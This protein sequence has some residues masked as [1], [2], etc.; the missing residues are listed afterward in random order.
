MTQL[1][2]WLAQHAGHRR[3][4]VPDFTSVRWVSSRL[5]QQGV[6]TL[7]LRVE[8]E[9]DVRLAAADP[10]PA[11]WPESRRLRAV[12]DA[13]KGLPDNPWHKF[14][15]D[16]AVRRA[17]LQACRLWFARTNKEATP[18]TPRDTAIVQ[19]AT[20]L[21]A[22]A[23]PRP[24]TP[25]R[26]AADDAPCLTVRTLQQHMGVQVDPDSAMKL[27]AMRVECP[28]PET[29]VAFMS[30]AIIARQV[31][32]TVFC[33]PQDVARWVNRLRAHGAP[34][35]ASLPL[36]SA[37]GAVEA[38]LASA[39]A[40]VTQTYITLDELTDALL[41]RAAIRDEQQA[42]TLQA[43]RTNLA[44]QRRRRGTRDQWHKR[45][46]AQASRLVSQLTS[47]EDAD[48]QDEDQQRTAF[49]KQ[50]IESAAAWL[51]ERLHQLGECRS[52]KTFLEWLQKNRVAKFP[53]AEENL[54]FR[55]FCEQLATLQNSSFKPEDLYLLDDVRARIGYSSQWIDD[56]P[57]LPQGPVIDVVPWG[58]IYDTTERDCWL[59]GLDSWP[60]APTSTSLFTSGFEAQAGMHDAV[61]EFHERMRDL[62][63]LLHTGRAQAL[64]WRIHDAS[65]SAVP[66]GPWVAS[67]PGASQDVTRIGLNELSPA[68]DV[69]PC[70]VWEHRVRWPVAN[71]NLRLRVHATS[72]QHVPTITPFTGQL[73]VRVQQEQFSIS[74]LQSWAG[75][76]WRY[77][78]ERLLGARDP[79]L[80]DDTWDHRETGT[81]VH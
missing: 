56:I 75:C 16:S 73:G 68:A 76:P 3:L 80:L 19:L 11:Y 8:V 6:A 74:S 65:G 71:D 27:P 39:L 66:L 17:L 7:G 20:A 61:A 26:T 13:L 34:V 63:L 23:P 22:A 33:A 57:K 35:R 55:A 43:A 52:P 41:S 36:A 50:R 60:P 2:Q 40:V 58:T 62:N 44:G 30:R 48:A 12:S 1:T 81:I 31:N 18:T 79:E 69:T 21:H 10:F 29:E 37:G 49:E 38:W 72:Q 14:S 9:S 51:T 59:T 70:S 53:S 32:A 28:N 78:S 25:F 42:D 45:I 54:F 67:L 77:F 5:A 15:D 4:L 47:P 64:S 24:A 46:Q